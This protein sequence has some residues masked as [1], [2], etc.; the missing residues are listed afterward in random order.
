MI[1]ELEITKADLEVAIH[2]RDQAREW[3][4]LVIDRLLAGEEITYAEI[5]DM[6]KAAGPEE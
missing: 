3:L 1:D 4:Q 6:R 2:E 5:C